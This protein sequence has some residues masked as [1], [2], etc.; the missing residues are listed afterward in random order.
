MRVPFLGWMVDERFLN[1]RLR[2]SSL[3]G[4]A[5]A[6]VA[7]LLFAYRYFHDHLWRWDLIAVAATFLGVKLAMMAWYLIT[8]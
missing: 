3:G 5:A 4:I 6:E 2:A 8:D 1:R 7:I